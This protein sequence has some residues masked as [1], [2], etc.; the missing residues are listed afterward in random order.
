[1]IID[2]HTHIFPEKIASA[3]VEA[4]AK[5]TSERPY[6]DGSFNGLVSALS[7][8]GV[9]LAVNLP[10]L[11]RPTQ[12]DSVKRF[13]AEVNERRAS[14]GTPILSFAGAHPSMDSIEE[15]M[16]ELKLLGFLGIKIHPDYQSTFFDDEGY[17]RIVKAAKSEGLAVVTH[18]GVDAAY[19]GEP[20][21]CSPDRVLRLL[22]RVGGYEKLVLAH[23]GG[24]KIFD[25]VFEKLAGEDVY[26]DTSYVLGSMDKN[27]F[28]KILEKHGEDRILF[29]SDSPWSDIARDVGLIRSYELGRDTEEKIFSLNAR[30]LLR[31]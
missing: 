28:L 25:E 8:A 4:L 20:I 29:A 12:F 15:K 17:V 11:T 23:Y 26:F 6:S 10:V 16:H 1:M 9:D 13:A 30:R 22:D 2:F 24:N 27:V 31:I 19:I 7:R 14:E 5:N 21:R 18:A 3:T